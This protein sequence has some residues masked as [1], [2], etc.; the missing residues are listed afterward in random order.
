[1]ESKSRNINTKMRKV[2]ANIYKVEV[3]N[4]THS[5]LE[6]SQCITEDFLSEHQQSTFNLVLVDV[7]ASMRVYSK[8]LVNYWNELISPLLPK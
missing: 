8:P 5:I 4:E 7:S 2:T 3:G 1:M 6:T